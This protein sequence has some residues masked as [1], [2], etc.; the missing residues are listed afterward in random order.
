VGAILGGV[1]GARVARRIP[2][3]VVRWMVIVI[4]LGLAAV[5]ALRGFGKT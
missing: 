5:F 1:A 3:R 2:P 4:G